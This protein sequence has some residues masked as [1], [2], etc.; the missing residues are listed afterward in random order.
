MPSAGSRV[1]SIVA[2]PP[3]RRLRR[4]PR[5]RR[6]NRR[7]SRSGSLPLRCFLALARRKLARLA[8]RPCCCR[9]LLQHLRFDDG[10]DEVFDNAIKPQVLTQVAVATRSHCEAR[11]LAASEREE[12]AQR[13]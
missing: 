13:Q 5:R 6:S 12:A 9:Y 1:S 10:G 3:L 4:L 2:S 8:V 11:E 7:Y